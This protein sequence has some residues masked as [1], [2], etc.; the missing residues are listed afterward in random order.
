VSGGVSRLPPLVGDTSS[1][2]TIACEGNGKGVAAADVVSWYATSISGSG[3]L[4]VAG[5][6]W[7]GFFA[8]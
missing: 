3:S 2:V 7:T 4:V 6:G 1:G 5:T 8:E